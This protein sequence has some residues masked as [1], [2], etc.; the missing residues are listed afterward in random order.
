ML[1]HLA[2]LELDQKSRESDEGKTGKWLR[3]QKN[4]DKLRKKKKY[5]RTT[6]WIEIV[7]CFVFHRQHTPSH[8]GLRRRFCLD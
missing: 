2:V 4:I 3:P 6:S 5:T 7:F 8:R 1:S